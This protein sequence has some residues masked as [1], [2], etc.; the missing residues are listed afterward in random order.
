VALRRACAIGHL[1]AGLA[2]FALVAAPAVSVATSSRGGVPRSARRPP[3]ARA[4]TPPREAPSTA[5]VVAARHWA[6]SRLGEVSFAVVDTAGRLHGRHMTRAVPS[7]SLVK[8]MLLV[9]WL[10]THGALDRATRSRLA[11]M[12]R[13]SDNDAAYAVHAIVGDAGL[14][15]VGRAAGMRGLVV[16]HGLFETGVTAAD[17][18]RLF[19][20]LDDLVPPAHRAFADRLLRTIVPEQTW[21]IPRAARPYLDVLFKGGWRR[22]LVHQAALL[23]Q[24]ARRIA[25]CVLTTGSPSMAY[26]TA[27][28]E[29]VARRLLGRPVV[30]VAPIPP[31]QQPPAGGPR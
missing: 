12:V 3:P 20:R 17:Q 26:G 25:I 9:A 6:A 4:A 16:G 19:A 10:R 7:A 2:G 14:R 27:T 11:A 30:R 13:A 29:G 18:A 5:H 21:G 8:T 22:G 23:R 15:A 31:D 1:A 24:G 28:I